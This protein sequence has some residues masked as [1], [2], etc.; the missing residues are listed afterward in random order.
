MY[1]RALGCKRRKLHFAD[2]NLSIFSLHIWYVLHKLSFFDWT[3]VPTFIPANTFLLRFS[4]AS[5]HGK[6]GCGIVLSHFAPFSSDVAGTI[7]PPL[8][9]L[10]L[11][12][13]RCS[14]RY[15]LS[16]SHTHTH[17]R[18]WDSCRAC[19]WRRNG[20][21]TRP[22]NYQHRTCSDGSGREDRKETA[23][24]TRI[25]ALR[26]VPTPTGPLPAITLAE[27]GTPRTGVTSSSK[28]ISATFF[29]IRTML[30]NWHTEN[31]CQVHGTIL[32]EALESIYPSKSCTMSDTAFYTPSQNNGTTA[33]PSRGWKPHKGQRN[34]AM[35]WK[36]GKNPSL[37]TLNQS[38]H[39]TSLIAKH[40]FHLPDASTVS[41][42]H[43][44]HNPR[45][46]TSAVHTFSRTAA[47][48][49]IVFYATTEVQIRGVSGT[50]DDQV[51]SLDLTRSHISQQWAV[52]TSK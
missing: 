27:T 25:A 51:G 18:Q 33:T 23:D 19:S 48:H 9:F 47:A 39:G 6:S 11:L 43:E 1:Q 49:S 2:Q 15:A 30:S 32:W 12:L 37:V 14:H 50:W 10:V 22:T 3:H 17:C 7:A 41:N 42:L 20:E 26:F 35:L 34:A 46:I 52:A 40:T 44:L 36:C 24:S 45:V 38:F 29:T 5:V 16:R 28:Q 13:V 8:L 21:W 31:A 4:L